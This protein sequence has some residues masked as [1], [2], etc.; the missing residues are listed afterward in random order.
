METMPGNY[1]RDLVGYGGKPPNPRWPK[2]ARL[3]L[4]FVL[5]YEEG[6]EP[7]I[8]DGDNRSE[9]HAE[10]A[11]V[12]FG[13]GERDLAAESS[14]E[15]GSRAG[16]W[17]VTKAFDD[18]KIPL[19]V[20]ACALAL[21]R[22]PP[23]AR[24]I[25]ERGYDICCHGYRWVQMFR[26]PEDEERRQITLAINSLAKTVGSRP[27]GWYCRYGPSINTRRLLVEE[28]GFLYDSDA[29]NDDLPYWTVVEG[30]PHLIVPY[31]LSNNDGK[32]NRGNFATGRDFFEYM[33]D[34]IEV[35]RAEG[36]TAPKMLSIGLH[37]RIIGQPA[38][39]A[40]LMRLLDHVI[41]QDDIWLCSRIEI[42]KHWRAIHPFEMVS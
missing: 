18:R 19:T 38:R 24:A 2:N 10:G 6:S 23:A 37:M 9:S 32:F 7:S 4:N 8:I 26:L 42:A 28:G 40:G 41:K 14:F 31:S 5:N 3:A 30:K 11:V 39:A 34:A 33:S 29:Y 17:R 1:A 15:Y 21:E 12:Q 20:F 16:F 25:A 35:L 36:A 13:P 22:N 27:L